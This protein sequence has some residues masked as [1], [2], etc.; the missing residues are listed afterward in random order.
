MRLRLAEECGRHTAYY[1]SKSAAACCTRPQVR[2]GTS[3]ISFDFHFHS[4][5]TAGSSNREIGIVWLKA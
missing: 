1:A 3:T 5:S 2:V 4:G